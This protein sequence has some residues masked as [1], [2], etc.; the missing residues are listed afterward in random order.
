MK[1]LIIED[2]ELIA[3]E[4]QDKIKR[5]SP[6][7]QVIQVLRSLKAARKWF[8]ENPEPDLIFMD[9][10]LSDGVSFEIFEH[11]KLACPVI[12]TTAYD[13]YAV[14]AFKVNGTDYLLK[15]VEE[16]ELVRAIEKAKKITESKSPF[17]T[18]MMQLIKK[19]SQT[20][21]DQPMYKE[22]F[23][24]NFRHQW[25]TVNVNDIACFMKDSIH[26]ILTF[27]GEKHIL[28]FTSMEEIEELL[29]PKKF[30]RA[31]RQF[32]VHIDAIQSVTSH[33]NQKLVLTLKPPLRQQI[34]ISR[35][36]SPAFKKWMDR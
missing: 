36:K 32:I 8:F 3:E 10:Q 25:F 19:L 4:L 11:F 28:D 27:K 15:P 17:P 34:D 20:Q 21:T 18:D 12:F 13:E 31:N 24:V 1:A 16:E 22:K 2:E 5:V 6:E 23:I 9:I 29:D 14:R 35:E 33:E 30:Y 26:Y 7:I